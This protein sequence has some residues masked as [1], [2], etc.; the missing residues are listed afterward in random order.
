MRNL[1]M[2]HGSCGHTTVEEVDDGTWERFASQVGHGP[3]G[4]DTACRSRM[5]RKTRTVYVRP[6]RFAQ[7][8]TCMREDMESW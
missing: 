8:V 5:G 3:F 2:F 4:P 1:L 6:L 7:C